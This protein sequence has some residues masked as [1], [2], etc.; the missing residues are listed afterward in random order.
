[1]CLT[2][3]NDLLL[4]VRKCL[5][6]SQLGYE[7][8][9]SEACEL[10]VFGSRAAGVH[11]ASSDVDVLLV[12]SHKSRLRAVNMD[13]VMLSP[14]EIRNP[15]WLGSE[16]A[17]HV[18]RYG[19]WIKGTGEWRDDVQ[20][21]SR[22]VA[23]KKQ[24]VVSLVRNAAQRWGRLHP[25]FHLKYAVMIRRELQ[26]LEILMSGVPIPPTPTLDSRWV[27]GEISPSHLL[28]LATYSRQLFVLDSVPELRERI[29]DP[30]LST[31]PDQTENT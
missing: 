20:I 11:S 19:H 22:A 4:L 24:R 6:P 26:R 16:L 18:A 3:T 12:T 8:L 28:E 14:E 13:C 5:L 2:K 7:K 15:F 25:V 9:H 29:S 17:S 27:A 23:R 31:L 30:I 1:M 21:S 10:V